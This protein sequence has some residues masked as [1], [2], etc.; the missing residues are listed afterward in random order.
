MVH[1]QFSV[2]AMQPNKSSVKSNASLSFNICWHDCINFVINFQ[3][4]PHV[5]FPVWWK[6]HIFVSNIVKAFL[7]QCDERL[8]PTPNTHCGS[9]LKHINQAMFY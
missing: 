7:K 8:R 2:L 3:L 5:T 4:K 6:S 1:Y 9:V